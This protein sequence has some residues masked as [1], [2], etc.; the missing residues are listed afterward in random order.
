MNASAWVA[1]RRRAPFEPVGDRKDMAPRFSR[2]AAAMEATP[3]PSAQVLPEDRPLATAPPAAVRRA[4]A[5]IVVEQPARPQAAAWIASEPDAWVASEPD[6]WVASEPEVTASAPKVVPD[7]KVMPERTEPEPRGTMAPEAYSQIKPPP[8]I[9]RRPIVEETGR[10]DVPWL[11]I[12]SWLLLCGALFAS[13]IG[14]PGQ[15]SL[16]RVSQLWSDSL[17]STRQAVGLG[18]QEA[19]PM[20]SAALPHDPQSW[21]ALPDT[22]GDLQALPP[23]ELAPPIAPSTVERIPGGPPLPQFKPIVDGVAAK[24]SNAFFEIGERLQEGGN[25]DAAIHMREQGSKL[26]PWRAHGG[27]EL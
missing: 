12:C 14:W 26:D 23:T 25:T 20:Q 21:T 4:P 8:V 11:G 9:P 19:T 13:L 3:P 24:F 15:T 22:G 2:F 18:Q 17:S 27:S 10:G 1:R 7:P 16:D 6:A 5:P